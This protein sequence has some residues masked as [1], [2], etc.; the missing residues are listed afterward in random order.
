MVQ[1]GL[2]FIFTC[3]GRLKGSLKGRSPGDVKALL[4]VRGMSMLKRA[5]IAAFEFSDSILNS[6]M[7]AVVGPAEVIGAINEI[8]ENSPNSER[9]IHVQE[10]ASLLDNIIRGLNAI[11]E[12]G[13]AGRVLI[14]S[15]DLPFINS[16]A[17]ADF[18]R[19]IPH[20]AELALPVVSKEQFLMQFPD[21]P[22]KFN[23]L[24]G[25]EFTLGSVI[26]ASAESIKMNFGLF[27]DAYDARKNPAKLAGMLGP[28]VIFK[29]LTGTL[30]ISDAEKRLSAITG[31]KACAV[32]D[33]S[34][35]LA[36]DVDDE[37]N[38][39]YAESLQSGERRV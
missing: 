36:Y 20:D 21:A 22:N 10:G 34:P 17:L 26:Y 25:G 16:E 27:Q 13:K 35:F 3:G 11:E 32:E 33:S 5:V 1:S 19:K 31:V 6:A 28:K 39:K 37:I 23:R 14:I 4:E 8:Q 12:A 15:P 24:K 18:D 2:S 30:A 38:L 29:F 7:F 9:F